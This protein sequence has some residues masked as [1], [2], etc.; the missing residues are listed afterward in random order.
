MAEMQECSSI[1]LAGFQ[2]ETRI[3]SALPVRIT[4]RS[5]RFQHLLQPKGSD[6]WLGFS[7]IKGQPHQGQIRETTNLDPYAIR[8]EFEA[9]NSAE[10]AVR[11]LSEAGQFWPWESVLWS[12]FQEW[13]RFFSWLCLGREA[14]MKTPEG[15]RA[16]LT[17][18]GIKTDEHGK[19]VPLEATDDFFTITDSEFTRARFQGAEL[20]K[21]ALLKNERTDRETLWMLQRFALYPVMV[22]GDRSTIGWYDPNDGLPP[23]NWRARRNATPKNR[24]ADYVPS[25]Q[26]EIHAVIPDFENQLAMIRTDRT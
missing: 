19:S 14:A 16:W 5:L 4:Y 15:K 17:A 21:A 18:D 26:L 23:E 10:A 7:R 22:D 13:Q 24:R 20:P 9:V 6:Y 8:K 11:F 25:L 1:D 3:M 2:S 12:Q